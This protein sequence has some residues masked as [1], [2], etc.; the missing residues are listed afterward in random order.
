MIK[1]LNSAGE[2]RGVAEYETVGRKSM[3]LLVDPHAEAFRLRPLTDNALWETMKHWSTTRFPEL[4][5]QAEIGPISADYLT[6]RWWSDTMSQ[7]A[8]LLVRVKQ[9]FAANP[10]ASPVSPEFEKLRREL[11]GAL[12]D[13]AGKS[14]DEFGAP[15]GLVAMYSLSGGKA[16]VRVRIISSQYVFTQEREADTTA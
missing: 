15:W 3:E 11:A 6:I 1:H 8:S 4:F 10:A 9:F 16:G 14:P 5:G 7:T 12:K 2:A 13:V